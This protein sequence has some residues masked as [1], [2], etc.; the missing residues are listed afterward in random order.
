LDYLHNYVKR[1]NVDDNAAKE[2]NINQFERSTLFW[3]FKQN[4]FQIRI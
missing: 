4:Y 1:L 3:S 2:H